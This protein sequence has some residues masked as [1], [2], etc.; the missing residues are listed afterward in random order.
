VAETQAM[1]HTVDS[2]PLAQLD[3]SLTSLC[4]KMQSSG[5]QTLEGEPAYKRTL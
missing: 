5:S 4:K 1:S 2:R 3:G